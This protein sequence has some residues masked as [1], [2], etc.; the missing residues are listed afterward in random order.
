MSSVLTKVKDFIKLLV[1]VINLSLIFIKWSTRPITVHESERHWKPHRR[2]DFVLLLRYQNQLRKSWQSQLSLL[3]WDFNQ[4]HY[5]RYLGRRT[6]VFGQWNG[7]NQG[8][9]CSACA[10]LRCLPGTFTIN[11][12]L[13]TIIVSSHEC[14]YL[15]SFRTN[16]SS[17]PTDPCCTLLP[18]FR[19]SLVPPPISKRSVSFYVYSVPTRFVCV[20]AHISTDPLQAWRHS[21]SP[22]TVITRD[23]WVPSLMESSP[24]YSLL[25]QKTERCEWYSKAIELN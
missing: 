22:P 12:I 20:C 21:W 25:R 4:R 15:I 14:H 9:T 11:H 18:E 6:V 3:D 10:W 7:G 23:S 19:M 1:R 2:R 17:S 8:S 16:S 13:I 5:K 24:T